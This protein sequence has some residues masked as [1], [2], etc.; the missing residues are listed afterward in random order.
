MY[1]N[2]SLQSF[3]LSLT[4]KKADLKKGFFVF[5]TK[6]SNKIFIRLISKKV[7]K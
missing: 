4:T 3:L 1:L 2:L 5:Y 7:I 6:T